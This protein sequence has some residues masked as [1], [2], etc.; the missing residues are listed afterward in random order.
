[1]LK[2]R[3]LITMFA[4]SLVVTILLVCFL[5]GMNTA[6]A[7][8]S[9]FTIQPYSS[10]TLGGEPLS[11]AGIN[12][13]KYTQKNINDFTNVKL[14]PNA[15]YFLINPK[16]CKNTSAENI[17]GTCTTVAAQ[18]LLGY[19][20]YYSD[21]RIIPTSVDNTVF[22]DNSYG[23]T[24]MHPVFPRQLV[25]GQGCANIGTLDTVHEKIF[26]KTTWA[27]FPGLGQAIGNVT[28]GAIK[29]LDAY[30]PTEI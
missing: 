8:V 1:M 7:K 11:I 5:F 14:I 22:L 16:H 29:F 4:I 20:N 28:N 18:M 19:H 15:N 3:Y 17:A 23:D 26:E 13:K 2:Q 9:D 25:R 24:A 21:R 30:T 6:Y 27:E 10:E 12:N